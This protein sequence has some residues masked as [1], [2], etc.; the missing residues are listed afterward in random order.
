MPLAFLRAHL[1]LSR[2]YTLGPFS[3]NYGALFGI[4]AINS[5]YLPVP[6]LWTQLIHD[7]LDPG[8]N[9]ISFMGRTPPQAA[10]APERVAMLRAHRAA[11]AALGGAL[12]RRPARRQP[13][14][15]HGPDASG[16]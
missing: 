4:A 13:V 10:D 8:A 5:D 15:R 16:R 7:A 12:R 14:R 6:S 3:P 2:F 1:G 11:Y 9:P